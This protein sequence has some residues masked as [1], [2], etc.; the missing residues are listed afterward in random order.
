MRESGSKKERIALR[1]LLCI[2]L[3]SYLY[4]PVYAETFKTDISGE[5]FLNVTG[6]VVS[7]SDGQPLPGATVMI[8]GTSKGTVADFDG[9]Y[10][11][12]VDDPDGAVLEFSFI[13]FRTVEVPVNNRSV[14][15][16][17]LEEDLARLDEVVVVGYGTQ[18]KVDVTSAVA[19]VKSENFVQAPVRDAGQ[20][21]QGKVAGLTVAVPSGDP[22]QGVKVSLRG[23]TTILGANEA[24]LVLIDGVPGDLNTVAPEDIESVD[25]LKDG[26]AA[27]IYGVRGSNGVV[28]ITTKGFK[29]GQVNTLDYSVQLST[30]Q[31][32]RKPDM[33]TAN[34]YKRQIEEGIRAG[35]WDNGYDT[36][37]FKEATQTPFSQVHNLTF[38]G[39]NS[40]TNYLFNLNYR[41]FDGIMRKSDN[42]TFNGRVDVE[43]NMFDGKL[44][45]NLGIIGRQ[46]SYTTTGDGVSFNNW[47]Y[48]QITIQN[49]TSPIRDENGNWFQE[50]IFDYDNPLARLYESD[51]RNK[52]QYTRYNARITFMPVEEIRLAANVTYDKYNQ[53]R[54]YAETKRHISTT[55]DSRNGYASIGNQEN[56]YR[57]I[58]LTGEYKKSIGDHNFSVLG[59]Y[60]YQE[61]E[62]FESWM[63]NWDFPTDI[64]GYSN[65][66][67]GKAL[68]EGSAEQGSNR[69][70]TNLISFFGRATY[71]YKDKYLLM[72]SIRYEAA[73]QLYK[74]KD[75]WGTFPAISLGWRINEESFMKNADFIDNLKIR[76][77]YGVTGNQP[78]DLFLGPAT[79]DYADY[80]YINGD[81]IRSLS[82]NQNPNPYLRWEEKKEYNIGL[83]YS[84]FNGRLYGALDYY[85]RKIDGLL[86]DYQ[87]PSPPN[88]HTVTRAN[89]GIMENK[90][91]ELDI[92]AIPVKTDDFTWTTQ[93]LF[94][95]NSNQLVSLSNDLYQLQSNYF[96]AGSTGVPI[97]THTHIV[98]IGKQLGDFHGYKV[99]DIS[100]D[101]YWIYEDANGDR[102][103]YDDFNRGF[104][105]KQVIG[106]GI[107]KYH[108]GW[109]NSFRYKNWDLGIT[110]RGS[111]DFQIINFQR[112]Y[113]ENTGDD[114][115]NRLRSAYDN[116]YGKAV[117]NK[118]VPLEFNSHYVEDGDFW[119]ID[120]ITLGYDFKDI[121]GD[122]I[123]SARV[124]VS[125]LNTFVITKYK[126][127]DPE[128]DWSGLSPGIDNR[129]K[130]PTTRT[131]TLGINVSF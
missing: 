46:N 69:R 92:S 6:K 47:T 29:D 131:F 97:Q 32:A 79:L 121:G 130:Y 107:P 102:V 65:I 27:A 8:K 26:S 109:N 94:S 83:D 62:F 21:L 60:G 11:L 44:K 67:Q 125:T 105:D 78:Q 104:E 127:I 12:D 70:E 98:E 43:H 122:L 23:N 68:A 38:R 53:S 45:F 103:E 72:A 93:L 91:L 99:V 120:N 77:G 1:R 128:V 2:L 74:T 100:D 16:V 87:V 24:P 129:D 30:Q 10:E 31:I 115:Y 81:W 56:I 113:Y 110:M 73:S 64:F 57:F 54:G 71:N 61:D 89:V 5:I 50:G 28:I 84:F 80:F 42:E 35:S 82:P 14:I 13:G 126:G 25:V 40:E 22:T 3:C 58:E 123:R 19:S 39:G 117:L 118:N 88:I 114:R 37:W 51:G 59:G 96:I 112:M 66:E 108:G 76:A 52:S 20:L 106:N 85:N 86:Y 116:I 17:E 63:Q 36:D 101:G 124:Y 75:P 95:T 33:L 111:F 90:G 9:N 34:D 55:R 4:A 41:G 119:K 49:P 18:R 7:A 48:R 15:D